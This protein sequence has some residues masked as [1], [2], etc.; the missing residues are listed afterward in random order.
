[1]VNITGSGNVGG[2]NQSAVN[3]FGDGDFWYEWIELAGTSTAN[4]TQ[5]GFNV[6]NGSLGPGQ[7]VF[8][9]GTTNA[10][11]L[12]SQAATLGNGDN[13]FAV[14]LTTTLTITNGG[15]Y[16]FNVGSDDGS[17]LYIDG[18]EIVENDGLQAF[19]TASG[20]VNLSLG[21]HEIVIIYF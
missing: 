8:N 3:N 15:N 2:P 16:T 19:D 9:A 18:V 20:S 13:D 6:T 5:A 10:V 7:T 17:R 11:N 14:R 21:Q 1:M 12:P 4:L